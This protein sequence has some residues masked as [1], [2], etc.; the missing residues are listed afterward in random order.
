MIQVC[1]LQILN[2]H[3][4]VGTDFI[5]HIVDGGGGGS[6]D[7]LLLSQIDLSFNAGSWVTPITMHVCQ[8]DAPWHPKDIMNVHNL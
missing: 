8:V 6:K 2:N 7:C 3:L 5:I 4:Q 1:C